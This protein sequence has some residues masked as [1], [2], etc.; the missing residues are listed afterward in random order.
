MYV[1]GINYRRIGRLMKVSHQSVVNWVTQAASTVKP[2]DAP[3]PN[4]SK[5]DVVELDELFTFIG[6]KKTKPTLSRKS[7]GK[8]VVS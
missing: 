1:D 4:L 6:D 8:H 2:E 5:D 3:S 7:T